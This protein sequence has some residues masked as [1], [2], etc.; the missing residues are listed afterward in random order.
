MPSST[1]R[2]LLPIILVAIFI[3]AWL[4]TATTTLACPNCAGAIADNSL[5]SSFD[6]DPTNPQASLADHPPAAANM[7]AG[8]NYSIMFMLAM[9]Y[10][11][12]AVFGSTFY[13]VM[14]NRSSAVIAAPTSMPSAG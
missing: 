12:V 7:A 14:R 2:T 5:Q 4:T 1:Q 10:I 8:F 3:G 11:L 9:P 6:I 13:F